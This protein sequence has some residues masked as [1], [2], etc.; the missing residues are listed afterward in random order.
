MFYSSFINHIQYVRNYSLRT[1]ES[2]SDDLRSFAMYL[3]GEHINIEDVTTKT[4]YGYMAFLIDKGLKPKSV[5]QHLSCLRSFFD[6]RCRFEEAGNNPAAPVKDMR[7]GKRLPLFISEEKM[8]LLI[9]K[10]LPSR[11]YKEA[12]TRIII[13]L[14]YHTGIRCAEMAAM[15]DNDICLSRNYIRVI[16]KGDKERYIPFGNELHNE[17]VS[18]MAIRDKSVRNGSC[19][20]IRTIQGEQ[21]EQWQIRWVCKIAL[22]RVAPEY[23]CHPHILR[24]TFATVLMNHGARVENV[25]KL[26]GHASIT[27]T[28]I[29]Q[30][31]SVDYL[32][33]SYNLAFNQ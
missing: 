19:F 18:Y 14:F 26:M 9:D 23:M 12:R 1:I 16:G 11:T 22:R 30:H 5:N 13:L 17:I 3:Q 31:T 7:V 20:F 29:Y 24:H 2:Y 6:Y 25:A 33:Q 15:K 4:I 21:C 28:S 8:N 27:T 32:R 10:F